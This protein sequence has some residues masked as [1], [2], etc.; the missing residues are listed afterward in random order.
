MDNREW[1]EYYRVPSG[2][3]KG[4]TKDYYISLGLIKTLDRFRVVKV[5]RSRRSAGS[6][7]VS[8]WISGVFYNETIEVWVGRFWRKYGN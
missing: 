1:S 8:M 6:D 2:F 4:V 3:N 7:V 5:E